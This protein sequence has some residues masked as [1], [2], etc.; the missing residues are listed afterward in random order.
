MCPQL[1]CAWLSVTPSKGGGMRILSF[2]EFTMSR[3]LEYRS[4]HLA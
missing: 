2:P 3:P 4:F 1:M